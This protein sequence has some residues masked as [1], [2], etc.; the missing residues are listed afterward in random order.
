M[1]H[2]AVPVVNISAGAPYNAAGA[3]GRLT[4]TTYLTGTLIR[5]RV[6]RTA[7]RSNYA[8]WVLAPARTLLA[9]AGDFQRSLSARATKLW[10]K[11]TVR[12]GS[13]LLGA[14]RC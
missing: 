14:V 5:Q 10:P 7:D 4:G 11:A 9:P 13:G 8:R 3:I 6:L 2:I 1:V 12:E